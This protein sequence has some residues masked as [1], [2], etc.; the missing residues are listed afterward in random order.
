MKLEVPEYAYM[1]AFLQMDGHL[2]KGRGKKGRLS[3]EIGYQDV[4]ILHRFR[5]LTP[6][7][8]TVGERTRATNF[9]EEHRSAIWT[10]CSLEARTLLHDLG[11]PH[12]RKSSLVTPPRNPFA[13][14]DYVRGLV[15]ADGSVGRTS[16]GLPFVALTTASTALARYFCSYGAL[17]T[18]AHRTVR[19]NS[20]DRVYNVLYTK[21]AALALIRHLYYPDCLALE[22]KQKAAREALGW[23]RPAGMK[24]RTPGRRWHPWE[25]EVLLRCE[26]PAEAA[27][28]LGRS[29]SSCYMRLWRFRRGDLSLAAP[30]R[31]A[32]EVRREGP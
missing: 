27:A 3:V 24:K 17:V 25:D 2:E 31:G 11:L 29:E 15:D 32:Q 8:S 12:G 30:G 28:L 16:Q 9:A 22:R 7:P 26:G 13:E 1:F 23:T 10:L 20:R 21:E 4:E 5:E 19:R 18:G 6:Y 14:A